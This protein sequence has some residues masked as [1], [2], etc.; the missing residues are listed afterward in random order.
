MKGDVPAKRRIVLAEKKLQQ[1]KN[2]ISWYQ[3]YCIGFF[4]NQKMSADR[5]LKRPVK[6]KHK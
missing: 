5:K 6:G 1:K 2:E 4:Q 3:N